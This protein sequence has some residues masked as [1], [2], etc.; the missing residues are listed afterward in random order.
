MRDHVGLP[1]PA[2]LYSF[3]RSAFKDAMRDVSRVRAEQTIYAEYPEVKPWI[4]D[5][6]GEKTEQSIDS[7]ANLWE[8]D[9]QEAALRAQRLVDI[10]FF[11]MLGK[12]EAPR[13]KVPFLYRDMHAKR[14]VSKG[15]ADQPDYTDE[16]AEDEQSMV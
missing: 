1:E 14:H 3:D 15:K 12:R 11:E 13:F 2:A 10:G 4:E 5:I 16:D 9:K 6:E 7:L 8:V